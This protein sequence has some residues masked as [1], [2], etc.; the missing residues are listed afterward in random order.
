[1]LVYRSTQNQPTK[2][3]VGRYVFCRYTSKVTYKTGTQAE[4]SYTTENFDS[5]PTPASETLTTCIV[6]IEGTAT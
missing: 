1:M 5:T 4:C 2:T 6:Y 3:T